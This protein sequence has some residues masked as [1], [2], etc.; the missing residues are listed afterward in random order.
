[1][2]VEQIAGAVGL[3]AICSAISVFAVMRYMVKKHEEKIEA[4]TKKFDFY[5]EKAVHDDSIKALH[6]RITKGDDESRRAYESMTSELIR[7]VDKLSTIDGFIQGWMSQ[8]GARVPGK[9]AK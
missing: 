6:D 7:V 9:R 5:V 4:H 2:A 1:M 8:N 3:S